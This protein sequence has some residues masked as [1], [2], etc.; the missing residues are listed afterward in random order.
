VSVRV[1]IVTAFVIAH[2]VCQLARTERAK[3]LSVNLE[4]EAHDEADVDDDNMV[5]VDDNAD[6]EP[7]V[8]VV[9]E[10]EEDDDDGDDEVD[11]G[12]IVIHTNAPEIVSAA[13]VVL[14][15]LCIWL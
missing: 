9:I 14:R 3:V 15:V 12:L 1:C 5:L 10:P 13:K 7:V 8:E 4:T 2:C 11:D 6:D